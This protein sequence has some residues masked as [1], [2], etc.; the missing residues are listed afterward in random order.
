MSTYPVNVAIAVVMTVLTYT[1]II[2]PVMARFQEA[3]TAVTAVL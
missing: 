3:T 1:M 2:A